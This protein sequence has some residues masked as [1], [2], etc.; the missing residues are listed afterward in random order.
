MVSFKEYSPLPGVVKVLLIIADED[1]LFGV[2]LK[3]GCGDSRREFA[4]RPPS[5]VLE[6]EDG[7]DGV[8]IASVDSSV[9]IEAVTS[10]VKVWLCRECFREVCRGT[11]CTEE[12]GRASCRERVF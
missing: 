11:R 12:I 5:G 6:V 4:S 2:V 7:L 9:Y 8:S 10:L 1:I 3:V